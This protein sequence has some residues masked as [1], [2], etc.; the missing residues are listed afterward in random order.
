MPGYIKDALHK[1]QHAA[2][3]RPEHAPHRWTP[4][5]YGAKTQFVRDETISPT[6]SDKDVNKL[7]QLTITRYFIMPG[8]LIK[9]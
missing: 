1:Y 9:P 5:T 7:Q 8:P 2:P 6:L 4:P 3:V